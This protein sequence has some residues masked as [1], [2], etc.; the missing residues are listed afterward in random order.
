MILS[1]KHLLVKNILIFFLLLQSCYCQYKATNPIGQ[2]DIGQFR[3][4]VSL[5]GIPKDYNLHLFWNVSADGKELIAALALTTSNLSLGQSWAAIAFGGIG[6]I[7]SQFIVCHNN[8]NSKN[9]V[10]IHEHE[11]VDI[12]I[13]P[14]TKTENLVIKPL[15]SF[16]NTSM[17]V[18]LFSRPLNPNDSEHLVIDANVSTKIMY[19]YSPT[20]DINYMGKSFSYHGTD[21]RGALSITFANGLVGSA[22]LPSFLAKQIHGFGMVFFILFDQ[23]TTYQL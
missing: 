17:Q 9:E 4:N 6:M 3:Y 14:P 2:V 1:C 10:V 16:G 23:L 8:Q 7:H 19:A 20:S 18:C 11:S 15:L 5:N 22:K 12:Y 21:K 13:T